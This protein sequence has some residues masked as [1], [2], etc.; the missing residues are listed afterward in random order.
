MLGSAYYSMGKMVGML[1]KGL[2]ITSYQTTFVCPFRI[3]GV[4]LRLNPL[5]GTLLLDM[6]YKGVLPIQLPLLLMMGID[7]DLLLKLLVL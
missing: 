4:L 7:L 3:V 5:L 2:H 6:R 1:G